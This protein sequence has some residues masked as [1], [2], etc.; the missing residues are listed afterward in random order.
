MN[1]RS[2]IKK[3]FTRSQP[4]R[5]GVRAYI[6][7]ERRLGNSVGYFFTPQLRRKLDAALGE[8]PGDREWA[9]ISDYPPPGDGRFR[10]YGVKIPALVKYVRK[11]RAASKGGD[12]TTAIVRTKRKR[13]APP[14]LEFDDAQAREIL[15]EAGVAGQA[16]RA[17]ALDQVTEHLLGTAWVWIGPGDDGRHGNICALASKSPTKKRG[18]VS[19]RMDDI[20]DRLLPI[21][22][23]AHAYMTVLLAYG[24][25]SGAGSDASLSMLAARQRLRNEEKVNASYNELP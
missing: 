11:M 6:R 25:E 7:E 17:A 10:R 4:R 18:S 8:R 1:I 23:Y 20:D 19:I 14:V 24:I 9:L 13:K 2:A 3:L 21:R 16:A 15:E 5:E 12:G 22:A